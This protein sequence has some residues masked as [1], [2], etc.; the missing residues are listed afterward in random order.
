[1][2]ASIVSCADEP[3]RWHSRFGFTRDH[4]ELGKAFA[5]LCA[6]R[7]GLGTD[8]VAGGGH[9]HVVAVKRPPLNYE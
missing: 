2:S 8:G 3:Y 1:M 5:V 7:K 9:V 6:I 4:F